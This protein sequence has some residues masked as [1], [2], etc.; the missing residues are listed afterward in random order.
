MGAHDIFRQETSW[1]ARGMALLRVVLFLILFIAASYGV[2]LAMAGVQTH[3]TT[4]LGHFLVAMATNGAAALVLVAVMARFSG[5]SFASYGYEGRHKLRN[6]LIGLASGI[7]VLAGQLLI[8]YLAGSFSLHAPTADAAALA[9]SALEM[10]LLFLIVGVTEESLCRG[11]AFVEASRA[12]SFWPAAAL[13]SAVFAAPHLLNSGETLAAAL[14]TGLFGLALAYSVRA[15]GTL[16]FAIGE[17]AGWDFGESFLF[18]TPDSGQSFGTPLFHSTAQGPG[19]L[20]GGSAG[21]EGSL[22]CILS[23]IAVA[24]IARRIADA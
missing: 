12:L 21:P 8:E 7:A 3:V 23:T 22:L 10:A 20:T 24:L 19:W 1:P 2:N 6:L 9:Q 17:H 16:W 15:T 5:R 14:Q 4:T 13:F 11:Y 18:G